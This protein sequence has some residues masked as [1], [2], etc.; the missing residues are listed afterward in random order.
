MSPED[1]PPNSNTSRDGTAGFSSLRLVVSES[2]GTVGDY[3][4]D[5]L[6]KAES[7]FKNHILDL[8]AVSTGSQVVDLSYY[9]DAS[10]GAQGFG[11][12]FSLDP[13]GPGHTVPEASTWAMALIGFAGVGCIA[14]FWR[15]RTASDTA[16]RKTGLELTML[17]RQSPESGHVRPL[18]R[19]F[20]PFG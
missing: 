20:P 4:F 6:G 7:F 1:A 2:D 5:T 18:S 12:N 10:G 3:D 15:A 11:F 17:V 16:R 13:P 14:R 19:E 8:G 9:L